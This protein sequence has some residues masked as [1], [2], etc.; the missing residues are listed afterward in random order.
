MRGIRELGVWEVNCLWF[1]A[2]H[3]AQHHISQTDFGPQ[4]PG[5][6]PAGRDSDEAMG[7]NVR[8]LFLCLI[9]NAKLFLLSCSSV[10]KL[11]RHPL[12]SSP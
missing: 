8:P 11:C 6:S 4:G 10:T 7:R 1:R 3:W 9:R 12:T 5:K 2:L